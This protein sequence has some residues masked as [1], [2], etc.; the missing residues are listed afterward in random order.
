MNSV[1]LC[2]KGEMTEVNKMNMV[3]GQGD[4]HIK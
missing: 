2:K 3:K 1:S 4:K